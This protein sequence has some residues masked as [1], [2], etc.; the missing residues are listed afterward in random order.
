M[1]HVYGNAFATATEI[2]GQFRHNADEFVQS[3]VGLVC[4]ALWPGKTDA[5]IATICQ[6]DPRNAR[7]YLS[8]ELP[9]PAILI[10]AI[11]C[12]LVQRNR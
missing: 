7:R 9:I 6:C 3:P 11:N 2:G 12:R 8:G 4:K 5:H 1:R 10:A